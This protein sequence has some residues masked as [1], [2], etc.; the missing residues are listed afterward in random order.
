[1]K[2]V[3]KRVLVT[4]LIAVMIFSLTPVLSNGNPSVERLLGTETA[5]A[6][7]TELTEGESVMVN[8]EGEEVFYSFVANESGYYRVTTSDVTANSG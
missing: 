7:T 4:C 2:S 5:Y 6:D 3:M 8:S 1:M